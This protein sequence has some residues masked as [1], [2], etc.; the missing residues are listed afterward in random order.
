[1]VCLSS[2]LFGVMSFSH[3]TKEQS[4]SL[5]HS[6]FTKTAKA[7]TLGLLA[8]TTGF[9]L[10]AILASIFT[11]DAIYGLYILQYVY[12]NNMQHQTVESLIEDGD[13]TKKVSKS[14][15]MKENK[16][17]NKIFRKGWKQNM[18]NIMDQQ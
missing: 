11:I 3:G 1:M 8:Y 13:S 16:N 6:Y 10:V 5:V 14:V 15:V 4:Q 12:T 7:I 17:V 2:L 18:W 9:T